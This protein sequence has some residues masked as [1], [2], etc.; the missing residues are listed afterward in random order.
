MTNSNGKYP[1]RSFDSD[2]ALYRAEGVEPPWERVCSNGVDVTDQ[3]DL[4]PA[5][6]SDLEKF[7]RRRKR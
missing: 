4:W 7:R 3:P 1:D 2:A 5:L 6:W